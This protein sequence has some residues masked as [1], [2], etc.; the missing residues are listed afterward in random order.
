ME[1]WE[2]SSRPPSPSLDGKLIA[3]YTYNH[4]LL[5]MCVVDRLGKHPG[6]LYPVHMQ[7]TGKARCPVAYAL[8]YLVQVT[9]PFRVGFDDKLE[10]LVDHIH[11]PTAH[12]ELESL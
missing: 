3:L 7:S 9:I 10:S 8:A 12:R 4:T 1:I 5:G 11:I 2:P 6:L